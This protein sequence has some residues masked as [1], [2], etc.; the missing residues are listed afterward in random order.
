VLD[1]ILRGGEVI[2]GKRT[3]RFRA[4]VGVQAD[5][6]VAIG[7]LREAQAAE[8]IDATRRIVAPG[9]ID[10]HNHSDGWMLRRPHLPA[11][12]RQGFTTE[13]LMSDGISYAPVDEHTAPE[14][15]FYLRSLNALRLDEYTGW[16]SL[17]DYQA[18]LHQR[19]VQNNVLQVPYGTL[20]TLVCGFPSR[21]IDDLQRKL[22]EAEIRKGMEAGAV[23]LSTGLDYQGQIHA[24]T[25]ELV[26]AASVLR[27]FD[28][29]YVTHVRYKLGLL[30]AVKEAVEIGKRARVKV[31]ISHLKPH[32]P[33]HVE[34]L[35]EYIDRVARHEVD[36]SFDVYPYL[37]GSTMLNFLLPYECWDHGPLGVLGTLND[38]VIRSRFRRTLDNY[39]VQLNGVHI[40][41]VP[42]K[43]N[44]R[45]QGWLLSD[46][47][48][49]MRRPPEEALL[50]LLIEERLAVLCVFNE[51]D[52]R[53]VHPMLQHELGMIGSDAIYH[54]DACVHPRAYGTSPRILG[55]CVRDWK[56]FSLEDAVY[57]LSGAAAERFQIADRG[58][59]EPRRFADLVVFDPATVH[60][61]AS[62]A[63]P[64]Q[65]PIG[66]DHV[67]VNGRCIVRDGEPRT[68]DTDLLG[69][70]LRRGEPI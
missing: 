30:P 46:Y 8:V 9:F 27:E 25:D 5:R 16:R 3:L 38:P 15:L 2:D 52:D 35:L 13:V 47:V 14:W 58:T 62:F 59:L 60:D 63:N 4:D 33:Q 7:D 32:Q 53:L 56:L 68:G 17:A 42:G 49:A 64:Q 29:P 21:R 1:V 57:K 37:P 10:V 70:S 44:A 23:A 26:D 24:T 11:K 31:H 50:N 67:L 43:E 55:R 65:Y 45:Y 34:E 66:I 36:L 41:W 20:R 22:I 48:A 6:I 40:A 12:T 51:G 54:D 18:L 28:A 19:N 61:P 69:R 39:R